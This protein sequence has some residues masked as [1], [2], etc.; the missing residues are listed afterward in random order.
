M[1]GAA[2]VNCA[3]RGRDIAFTGEAGAGSAG[4]MQVRRIQIEA[5]GPAAD[6][7][8]YNYSLKRVLQGTR[9][10]RAG[11]THWAVGSGERGPTHRERHVPGVAVAADPS[12]GHVREGHLPDPTHVY[13]AR[14][15]RVIAAA[16]GNH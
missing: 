5:H 2:Q 11:D 14:P 7:A 3:I 13:L 15:T 10:S 6:P 9:P 4:L 8:V 12:A 16:A 1:G